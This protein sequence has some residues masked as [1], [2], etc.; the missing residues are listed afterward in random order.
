MPD[1][2]KIRGGQDRERIDAGQDHELRHWTKKLGVSR[3]RLKEAIKAV[4]DRADKVMEHLRAHGERKPAKR[5][6]DEKR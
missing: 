1:D 6:G 4:G 2:P 3:D 5:G